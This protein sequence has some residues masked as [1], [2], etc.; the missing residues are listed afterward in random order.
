M[1]L[2]RVVSQICW[3]LVIRAA[4]GSFLDRLSIT[5]LVWVMLA[6]SAVVFGAIMP[7]APLTIQAIGLSVATVLLITPVAYLSWC[8]IELPAINFG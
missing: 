3:I 5:C 1:L 4:T 8:F 6:F 7:A 2:T